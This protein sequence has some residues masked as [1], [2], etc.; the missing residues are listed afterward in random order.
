MGAGG[1]RGQP[2]RPETGAGYG[3]QP[4]RAASGAQPGPGPE[5]SDLESVLATPSEDWVCAWT[6]ATTSGGSDPARVWLHRPHPTRSENMR[7]RTLYGS[8][9]PAKPHLYPPRGDPAVLGQGEAQAIASFKARRWVGERTH[10]WMNRFRR[11][12]VRWDKSP[13]NYIP[14]FISP[15]PLSLSERLEVGCEL[16]STTRETGRCLSTALLCCI[17]RL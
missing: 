3:G 1:G 15:V 16:I 14:F 2:P 8:T 6:R 9:G 12:L 10:S 13:D 5:E 17:S 4:P 11:I 7:R